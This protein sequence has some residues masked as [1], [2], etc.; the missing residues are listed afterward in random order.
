MF[1]SA[2]SAGFFLSIR[3]ESRLGGLERKVRSAFEE[4]QDNEGGILG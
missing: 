1:L 2:V 3:P 4:L